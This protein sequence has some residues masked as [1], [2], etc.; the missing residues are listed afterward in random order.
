[1]LFASVSII[2]QPLDTNLSPSFKCMTNNAT[3]ESLV[4]YV[5][6]NTTTLG[7]IKSLFQVKDLSSLLGVNLLSPSTPEDY[8]IVANQTVKVPIPCRCINN[9]GLSDRIPL[10]TCVEGDTAYEIG[11]YKFS[12]LVADHVLYPGLVSYQQIVDVNHV[13][14]PYDIYVGRKLWIPLPCSCDN[15]EGQK[16]V[17]YAHVMAPR[18]TLDQVAAEFG[19]TS[20]TLSNLNNIT[21]PSKFQAVQ[22]ID[23]P[24]KGQVLQNLATPSAGNYSVFRSLSH[25]ICL[26]G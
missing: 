21:D 11:N 13:V 8:T 24:L 18:S 23:I 9:T 22:V 1:M 14:D 17:H 19:T 20:E 6:Q 10:Y 12:G 26:I 15:V 4:G 7:Q 16:V 2:V 5:S 3:C 25:K